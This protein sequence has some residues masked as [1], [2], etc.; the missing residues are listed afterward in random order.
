LEQARLVRTVRFR[1]RH[2]YRNPAWT[3]E[4]N[5]R[6]FGPQGSAHEHDWRVAV[7]VT[8][9]VDPA[10]G[11]CCDLGRLDGALERLLRGWDGGDLN[12]LIPEVAA[13]VLRPS[14]ENLARWLFLRLGDAVT[15]PAAL[16]RVEVHESDTLG[17]AY[18][19]A[20][21]VA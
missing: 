6:V 13:G 8:G 4:E 1:A 9:P 2:H 15:D 11:W 14:T 5:V 19:A 17:A 12:A 3:A 18:P 10:T 16:V 20:S 7:H 21:G